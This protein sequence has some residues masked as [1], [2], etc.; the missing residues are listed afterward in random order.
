MSTLAPPRSTPVAAD[1]SA[2]ISRVPYLPGLDGM[3]ALAVVAVMVYHANSDWL[4]GGFLGVE[5]FFVISGYLI[6]LLLISERE[7]TYRISLR[8][9]WMRRARRLL[10]ALFTMMAIVIAW[11]AVFKE[12]ALGQLRGDVIAGVFYVSNYYQIWVGQGYTAAGDFAPLRHLWSLAVEEQ[13]YIVWPLVMAALLRV[14]PRRVVSAAKWMLAAAVLITVAVAVMVPTGRIGTCE[15]D[16]SAYWTVGER[17]ISKL[18]FLYLST[19]TRAAGLLLGSAFAL[20]WRPNAIMRGPLRAKAPLVDLV[21]LL[22][23]IGLAALVWTLHIV[24]PEGADMLLF[25]GGFFLCGLLTVMVIAAATHQRAVT[26]R[27]LGN[28]VL[29]WAGTRSYGL[30]LYHWPI[31]QA[32]R[33]VAGNRLSLTQFV[34]AMVITCLVTEASYRYVETPIRR[35]T[36]GTWW[37]QVRRSRDPLQR[38]VVL[39]GAATAVVLGL[40]GSVSLATAPLQQNEIAETIEAGAE[41][42]TDLGVLVSTTTTVAPGASVAPGT[43]A[44]VG[45]TAPGATVAPVVETTTLPPTTTAPPLP[46]TPYIAVGDSVMLGA[47]PALREG[48][49]VVDAQES[50]QMVDVVPLMQQLQAAGSFGTAVIVHLGTNGTIGDDTLEAFMATLADVPNVVVLTVRADRSW[51]AGVNEKLRALDGRP[52]VIVLDWAELSN[53]CPG[54]CFAGDGIHLRPDGQ[55]YYSQL[56][57]DV[58]GIG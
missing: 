5:I 9:F 1:D 13:F 53:A 40:F 38:Q 23:V 41:A 18:D 27:L 50:R 51:T 39:A 43:A 26:G 46:P 11:T 52:N 56:I 20:V 17:C 2:F 8:Q 19:P 31:F 30:Y 12:E 47:A 55:K 25:R 24:T 48:G 49:V 36:L 37:R 6:T 33:G 29:L 35:G 10:P 54:D 45:T 22:G 4:P 15:T 32:I 14:G 34:I 7:R 44:P 21:A 57:F 28:P 58:L 42:T 16:P 3:R